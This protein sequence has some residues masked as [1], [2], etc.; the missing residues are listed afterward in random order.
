MYFLLANT[1]FLLV[2]G[3][4]EVSLLASIALLQCQNVTSG[5]SKNTTSFSDHDIQSL[6]C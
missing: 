3:A 5:C 2:I 1:L 4:S 6:F